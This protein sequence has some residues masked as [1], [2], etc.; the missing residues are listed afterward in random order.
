MGEDS[1]FARFWQAWP[2][3][4]RPRERAYVERVFHRLTSEDRRQAASHAGAYRA[5]QRQR[6]EFAAMIL[7][8]RDRQFVE[9]EGGPQVDREGFFVITR[10]REEWQAWL[11]HYRGRFNQAVLA[12]SVERGLL[13]TR[14]RWPVGAGVGAGVGASA[15]QE[16]RR[17]PAVDAW[18]VR[19]TG[20]LS[21]RA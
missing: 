5:V 3:P 12:S 21:R 10:V 17:N 13:L 2:Q 8:L 15:E 19:A 14:T 20:R 18:I 11:D 9:F 1:G 7:Y 4:D 6:G 16:R